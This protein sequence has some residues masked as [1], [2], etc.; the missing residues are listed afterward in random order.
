MIIAVD[1]DGTIVEHE[2]PKIGRPIPFA[3][4]TLL[5][6]KKDRH[7]LILWTVRDGDLLQEA[8]DYCEKK[9]LT[10]YAANKNYPEEDVTTAS[11]KLN[12]DLFIDDRNL[13]G[14]PDWGVIYHAIQSME[15]GETSFEKLM[16]SAGPVQTN[17]RKRNF[18]I[19]LGEMFER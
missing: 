9:G 6:L 18:L 1:F 11:R 15:R 10:F 4:E 8:V 3:I 7:Q 5:Q 13:G 12:A 16:M 17:R 19:R 14:L 2:Y